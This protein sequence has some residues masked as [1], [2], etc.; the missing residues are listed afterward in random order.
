MTS[1]SGLDASPGRQRVSIDQTVVLDYLRPNRAGHPFACALFELAD[2]G[3]VELR[4]AP[5]GHRFDAWGELRDDIYRMLATTSLRESPQLAYLS[6]QTFP[7]EDLFPGHHI[8]G[9]RAAWDA[10]LETWGSDGQRGS[11]PGDQDW[12]HVETAVADGSIALLTGDHGI[13][14]MCRKL[15][16]RRF[17]TDATTVEQYLQQHHGWA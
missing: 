17:R 4:I 16:G 7:A 5:Q 15:R 8:E 10:E 3:Q 13:H 1:A 12:W 14:N 6:E 11:K 2:S 9:L